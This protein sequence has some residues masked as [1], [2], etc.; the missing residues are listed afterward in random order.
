M[1]HFIETVVA[2]AVKYPAVL[3]PAA[4]VKVEWRNEDMA[5]PLE[6]V[7]EDEILDLEKKDVKEEIQKTVTEEELFGPEFKEPEF[8]ADD[9]WEVMEFEEEENEYSREDVII[10]ALSFALLKK[11]QEIMQEGRQ[12]GKETN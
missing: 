11:L 7:H 1:E 5:Q 12:N 6:E 3:S 10:K 8:Y 9:E 4:A 2:T